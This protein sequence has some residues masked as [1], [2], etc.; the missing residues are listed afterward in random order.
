M[1]WVLTLVGGFLFFCVPSRV[2][3]A[4]GSTDCR[5][6]LHLGAAVVVP[7]VLAWPRAGLDRHC[8]LAGLA[9]DDVLLTVIYFALHLAGQ[10]FFAPAHGR[11]CQ[12]GR[13]TAIHQRRPG[14][15]LTWPRRT[16]PRPRAKP[17]QL[18]DLSWPA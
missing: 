3:L 13:S 5:W 10:L 12:L 16:L 6:L 11:L 17:S 9:G 15:R 14:S 2:R 8:P 7:Q 18:A 1:G 4:V